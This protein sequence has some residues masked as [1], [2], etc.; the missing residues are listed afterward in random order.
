MTYDVRADPMGFGIC[1]PAR[2]EDPSGEKDGAG[3]QRRCDL[4]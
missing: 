4:K 3:Y 2:D 1:C